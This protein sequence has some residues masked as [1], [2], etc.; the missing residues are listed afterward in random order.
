[1]GGS[2]GWNHSMRTERVE[3]DQVIEKSTMEKDFGSIK[4][5]VLKV[6]DSLKVE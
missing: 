5:D 1:M 2:E 6:L 4:E 3:I